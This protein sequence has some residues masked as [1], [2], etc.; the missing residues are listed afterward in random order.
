MCKVMFVELLMPLALGKRHF[1]IR[2]HFSISQCPVLSEPIRAI[3]LVFLSDLI[4]VFLVLP[5]IRA[6]SSIVTWPFIF[7]ASTILSSSVCFTGTFTGTFSW[8][9]NPL[10]S[11]GIVTVIVDV[12]KS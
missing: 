1:G 11:K 12:P 10:L 6:I 9:P 2:R 4:T 8:L 7:M 5:M 3:L